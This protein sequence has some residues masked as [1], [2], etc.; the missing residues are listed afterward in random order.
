[1]SGFCWR[2]AM[3]ERA[4]YG[5][6][7]DGA[8]GEIESVHS[9]YHTGPLGH[10]G[11]N[12]RDDRHGL[13]ACGTGSTMNW[14]SGDI[15]VEQA[16]HSVDK[17]NWAMG[18]RPPAKCDGARRA[19]PPRRRGA[20]RHLRS[21]RG[22]LRVGQRRSRLPHLPSGPQLLERQHRLDRRQQGDRIRERLGAA[23]VEPQV[24]RTASTDVP[25]QGRERPTCTRPS[26]TSSSRRSA[27]ARC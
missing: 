13:R 12:A 4:V 21:L 20:W 14:L 5:E 7:N 22:G 6:I 17:M 26:T 9:T 15:I 16:V 1:M 10:P 18:N 23:A 27:T 25:V 8:L 2:Y 19:R 24:R 3:P 11:A